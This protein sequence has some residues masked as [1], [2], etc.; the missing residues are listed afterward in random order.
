V[1]IG[2][3][4]DFRALAALRLAHAGPAALGGRKAPVDERFMH[5]QIAFVVERLREKFENAPKQAGANPALKSPV[6]GLLRGIAVWQVGPGSAGSQDPEDAV[7]HRAI[8]PPGASSTVWSAR[9]RG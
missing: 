2:D 4:H 3:G 8:L 5:V 9:Q 6:A 1:A 7:E